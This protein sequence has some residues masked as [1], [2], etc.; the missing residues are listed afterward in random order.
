M[1][2]LGLANATK[3]PVALAL[4]GLSFGLASALSADARR[5]LFSLRWVQG[6]A[7]AVALGLPWPLYMFW[8][9]GSAFMDGY[10]LNE[11]IR[12]FAT[13]MYP[14]QPAWWFYL[15]IIGA[16]ML[17]WTGILIARGIELLRGARRERADVP[18]VLL[19]SWVVAIVGFFTFSHFKLD[20]YVFPASP[21]LCIICARAWHDFREGRSRSSAMRWGIRLVGPTL[22]GAGAV[23]AYA[24]LSVLELPRGFLVVPLSLLVAGAAVARYGWGRRPL[25]AIPFAPVVA[26]TIVFAGALGWVIPRLE[27]GKVV[28]DVASWVAAHAGPGDRVATFRLNRWNT[29]YRFYVNRPVTQI[30]SDEDARVFFSDQTRFYCVMTDTLYDALRSAGVP[31]HVAYEREGRLVTSGRALWR[32]KGGLTRFIVAVPDQVSDRTGVVR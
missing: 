28:P 6:M 25:P 30:E 22:V 5:Q 12:V 13:P 4:C 10:V 20:H 14:G 27:A 29:A 2:S 11:N 8:R 26:M 15:S 31:M 19:W 24:A 32:R 21:A 16:G 18:S 17:P 3:G 9:F 7:I 1:Y 23:M